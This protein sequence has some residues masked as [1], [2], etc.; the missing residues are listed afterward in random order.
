MKIPFVLIFTCL[1]FSACVGNTPSSRLKNNDADSIVIE[2]QPTLEQKLAEE[3]LFFTQPVDVLSYCK[4]VESIQE[5]LL[6]FSNWAELIEKSRDTEDIT[7]SLSQTLQKHAE[8]YQAKAF[9]IMRREYATLLGQL[10]YDMYINVHVSG[11]GNRC[12]NFTGVVFASRQNTKDFY[13]VV[14]RTI[15]HLRFTQVV[16]LWH[17]DADSGSQAASFEGRDTD[18]IVLKY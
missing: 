7:Q 17:V 3:L 12:I 13:D 9:P 6:I 18:L 4:N 11:R 2:K 5:L 16:F 1:L 10:V 15:Y 8:Q 14:R